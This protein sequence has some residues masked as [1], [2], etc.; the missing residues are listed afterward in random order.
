MKKT[1]LL[2]MAALGAT[3]LSRAAPI[4]FS[5]VSAESNWVAHADFEALRKSVV[6][7][8]II[9]K[10]KE[11]P[12]TAKGITA[13]KA[14]FGFDLDALSNFTA[15]G[16]GEP[17]KAIFTA[18]GGFDSARLQAMLELNESYV[19]K[20]HGDTVIHLIDQDKDDPKAIAFTAKDELLGTPSAS[21]TKHALDVAHGKEPSLKPKAIHKALSNLMPH[22]V[23]MAAVDVKGVAEFNKVSEGPEAVIIQKA[24]AIG[25]VV[26]ETGGM[27][28]AIA[29]LEA[30]D[31]ETAT[32]VENIARGF[33]S[34]LALGSD[35]DPGLA[36]LLAKTKTKVS[37]E[38]NTVS[39]KL[40]IEVEVAKAIISQG[41]AKKQA[42]SEKGL[43]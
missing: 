20:M 8:F 13:M 24:R 36:E 9:T 42:S 29:L 4:D 39:V 11:D 38:G 14:F 5:K 32:H 1:I 26:G 41:I 40:G 6:G 43:E 37:R 31:E 21:F 18:K 2:A 15:Y 16:R 17:N 7:S 27:L 28:I 35:I 23:L 10:A 30:A 12:K 34:L 3:G 19:A 22:P 33:T 25:L